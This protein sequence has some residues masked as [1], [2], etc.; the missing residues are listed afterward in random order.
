MPEVLIRCPVTH[1]L[2]STG[3]ALDVECFRLAVL[4]DMTIFCPFCNRDH[5]WQKEDAFL[6]RE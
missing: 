1:K 5:T 2:L 4:R 6:R 3:V